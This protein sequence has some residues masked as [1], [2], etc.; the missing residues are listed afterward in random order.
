M[1]KKLNSLT[2]NEVHNKLGT[3][4]FKHDEVNF[5]VTHEIH[6]IGG[7]KHVKKNTLSRC[8][9]SVYISSISP[10]LNAELINIK[11]NKQINKTNACPLNKQSSIH[12]CH[13]CG[14]VYIWFLV[15]LL[16]GWTNI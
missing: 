1:S 10:S 11:I 2:W 8:K 4:R 13:A 12:S 16:F 9:A 3:M 14:S 15:F 5:E 7:T 6:Q